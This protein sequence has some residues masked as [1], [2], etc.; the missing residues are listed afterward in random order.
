MQNAPAPVRRGRRLL[1]L[2]GGDKGDGRGGRG[3]APRE[4]RANSGGWPVDF[5]FNAAAITQ[6]CYYLA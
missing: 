4:G 2:R 6:S 5:Q 3:P 1:R